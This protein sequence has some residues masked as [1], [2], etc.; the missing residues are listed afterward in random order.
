MVGDVFDDSE[1]ILDANENNSTP[2][3]R[4]ATWKGPEESIKKQKLQD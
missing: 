1:D 4:N 3:K 2:R